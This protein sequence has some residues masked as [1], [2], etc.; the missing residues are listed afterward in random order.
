MEQL[1]PAAVITGRLEPGAIEGINKEW[2]N[3]SN[4]DNPSAV[5]AIAKDMAFFLKQQDVDIN[6]G[7]TH[8]NESICS[9]NPEMTSVGYMPI[10][11]APAHERLLRD[12]NTLQH[13]L[14]NTMSYLQ[15]M[16]PFIVS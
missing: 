14:D 15:L 10:V 7:W 11:Q 3:G 12:A 4:Y 8:F 2:Y 1:S 6:T 13:N 9:A 16:K 5:Q